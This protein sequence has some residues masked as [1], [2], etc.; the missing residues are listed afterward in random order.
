MGIPGY[1]RIAQRE[2]KMLVLRFG[3]AYLEYQRKTGGFFP[4]L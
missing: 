1:V 4:R 2:E 3:D